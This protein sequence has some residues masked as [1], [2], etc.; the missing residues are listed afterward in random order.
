MKREETQDARKLKPALCNRT[1][2]YGFKWLQNKALYLI[3]LIHQATSNNSWNN[4][5]LREFWF[6]R[7]VKKEHSLSYVTDEQGSINQNYQ[8]AKFIN[9]AIQ[10]LKG[11]LEVA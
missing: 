2:Y 1:F 6:R 10:I 5:E 11:L 4:L 7:L 9:F 8:A 3:S